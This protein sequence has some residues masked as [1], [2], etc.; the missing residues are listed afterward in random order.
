MIHSII[1]YKSHPRHHNRHAQFSSLDFTHT[2]ECL[3][4]CQFSAQNYFKNYIKCEIAVCY[5][6]LMKFGQVRV[7]SCRVEFG[8]CCCVGLK[9]ANSN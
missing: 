6:K 5:N 2:P 8:V 1:S 3:V 9:I 4:V 7:D